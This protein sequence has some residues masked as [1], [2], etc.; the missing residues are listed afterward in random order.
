MGHSDADP[1]SVVG[2]VI[3][4]VGN[5]LA[6]LLVLKIMDIH[7]PRL[8]LR[9]PL[10]TG[11]PVVTNQLFFL[12]IDGNHRLIGRLELE[13]ACVDMLELGIAVRVAAS[14]IGLGIA[15]TAGPLGNAE[16]G[17]PR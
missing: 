15:L 7:P 5:G 14:L 8:S 1:A 6:Q 12:G 2:D 4:A 9:A 11:V 10:R 3:D 16:G 13:D 17:Y